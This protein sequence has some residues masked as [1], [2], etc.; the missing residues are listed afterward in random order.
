M[1]RD[2]A[3]RGASFSGTSDLT[4]VAPIRK[5]FVPALDAVTYKTRV[6]RVLKALHLGRQS[7]HEYDL[8]RVL[9]DAV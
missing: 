3:V 6:I 5:G 9:S 8:A 2:I 1:R 7:G 4:I